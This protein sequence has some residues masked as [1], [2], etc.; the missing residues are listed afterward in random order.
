MKYKFIASLKSTLILAALL[1]APAFALAGDPSKQ[2]ARVPPD[3]LRDGVIYEIFP[4]DFPLPA[5]STA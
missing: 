4:R 2:T 5:T 1:V 3:W